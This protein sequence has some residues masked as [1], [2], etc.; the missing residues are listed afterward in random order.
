[1]KATLLRL[2]LCLMVLFGGPAAAQQELEIIPLRSQT[3]DQVLPTLLPLLE[4]LS[5][6]RAASAF[7]MR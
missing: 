3:L 4:P 7:S 2:L 1:M 6:M 5:G